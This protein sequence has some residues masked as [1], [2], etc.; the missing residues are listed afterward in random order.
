MYLEEKHIQIMDN[1]R[2][3][4]FFMVLWKYIDFDI[5]LSL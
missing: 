2:Y 3:L 1:Y 4:W 5:S